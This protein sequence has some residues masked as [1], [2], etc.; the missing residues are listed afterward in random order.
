MDTDKAVALTLVYLSAAFNII[1]ILFNCL[2]VDGTVGRW[3][4]S[5]L[6]NHKQEV[7]LDNNFS[8]AFSLSYG[9]PQGPVLS[10]LLFNFYTTSS[11]I[12]FPNSMSPCIRML[13][14][15]KYI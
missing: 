7:K 8:D 14:T 3:I 11:V 2:R 15:P 12:L 6:T 13:L 5:Y 9:V 10:P 1:D 4:K